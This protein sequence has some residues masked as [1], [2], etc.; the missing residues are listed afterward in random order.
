MKSLV[1]FEKC[2]EVLHRE[3]I[4]KLNNEGLLETFYLLELILVKFCPYLYSVMT[5][6]RNHGFGR[7]ESD[8]VD[9]LGTVLA[10]P[11]KIE[12]QPLIDFL[13]FFFLS[14]DLKDKPTS[15][16]I[17]FVLPSGLDSIPEVV[18]CIHFSL[19]PI[20]C[21]TR[22][23][24][25]YIGQEFFPSSWLSLTKKLESLVSSEFCHR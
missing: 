20:D 13:L 2:L 12:D 14:V 21:K 11:Q 22:Y 1:I 24:V 9:F 19:F 17:F 16:S 10:F 15:R 23:W 3:L 7:N 6:N 5:L 18:N 25:A 4:E 8:T